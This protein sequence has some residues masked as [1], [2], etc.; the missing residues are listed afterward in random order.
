M[1]FLDK[2]IYS[3]AIERFYDEQGN[4]AGL[5]ACKLMSRMY[6]ILIIQL[7]INSIYRCL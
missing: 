6:E 5:F 7:K 1:T 4:E 2:Y 3:S